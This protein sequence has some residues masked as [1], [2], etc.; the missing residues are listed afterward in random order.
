MNR[1][2]FN[3]AK[4]KKVKMAESE[5]S[6]DVNEFTSSG[7]KDARNSDQSDVNS[8]NVSRV[9]FKNLEQK[10]KFSRGR[11]HMNRWLK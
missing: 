11:T 4:P 3:R 2:I 1:Q 9:D 6:S 5:I 10:L 7:A 8:S